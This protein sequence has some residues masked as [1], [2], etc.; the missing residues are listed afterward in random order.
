MNCKSTSYVKIHE[1]GWFWGD[2]ELAC[3][4]LGVDG[5]KKEVCYYKIH[6]DRLFNW[7]YIEH[8]KANI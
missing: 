4:Q 1:E 6:D 2:S 5:E 3:H 8:D 7:N